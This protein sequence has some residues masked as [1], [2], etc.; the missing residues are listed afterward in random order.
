MNSH[1]NTALSEAHEGIL[2]QAHIGNGAVP[3]VCVTHGMAAVPV[4]TC[5]SFHIPADSD[6]VRAIR[7]TPTARVR[8]V[9]GAQT[10]DSHMAICLAQCSVSLLLTM[11]F[12]F[13]RKQAGRRAPAFGCRS[14]ATALC[15]LGASERR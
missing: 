7:F 6:D 9:S 1:C 4:L 11:R 8:P 12:V 14:K 13:A 15:S 2:Y 3:G 10:L 5:D